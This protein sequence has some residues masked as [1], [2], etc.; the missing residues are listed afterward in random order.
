M[1]PLHRFLQDKNW[2]E[3]VL[4]VLMGVLPIGLLLWAREWTTWWMPWPFKGQWPPGET[5]IPSR[6][7]VGPNNEESI[8]LESEHYGEP[9]SPLDRVAD[10]G[11]DSLGY[12]IGATIRNIALGAWVAWQLWKR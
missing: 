8:S 5:V 4:H 12:V 10:V 7:L 3:D 11:R 6:F 1:K 9:H 2:Y